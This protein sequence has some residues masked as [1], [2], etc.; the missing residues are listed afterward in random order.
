[1]KEKF[2]EFADKLDIY[3]DDGIINVASLHEVFIKN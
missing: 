2:Y 3:I 1:M